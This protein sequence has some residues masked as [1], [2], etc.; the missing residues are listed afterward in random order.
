MGEASGETST[1][2][3]S[4]GLRPGEDGNT[5]SARH[6]TFDDGERAPSGNPFCVSF[7]APMTSYPLW[8]WET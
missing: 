7:P 6:L 8:A 2:P 5:F 4:P 1:M 3:A